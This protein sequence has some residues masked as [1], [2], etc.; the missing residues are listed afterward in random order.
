M[1]FWK[2]AM[3]QTNKGGRRDLPSVFIF[4]YSSFVFIGNKICQ[5][6]DP[7]VGQRSTKPLSRGVCPFSTFH[8]RSG[9]PSS[10]IL[11]KKDACSQVNRNICPKH[12]QN[13]SQL[14]SVPFNLG[15]LWRCTVN[16]RRLPRD[17]SW[18]RRGFAQLLSECK[19]QWE[20]V[21]KTV[22]TLQRFIGAGMRKVACK[23]CILAKAS[24]RPVH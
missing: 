17:R 20:Q 19:M 6:L 8:V 3:R 22:L 13:V 9:G 1:H 14:S 18:I 16:W 11:L 24:L 5:L 21:W 10:L 12:K 4:E 7:F 15:P 2:L 23:V